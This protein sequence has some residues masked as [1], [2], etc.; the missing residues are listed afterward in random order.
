MGL[1]PLYLTQR[2]LNIAISTSNCLKTVARCCARLLHAECPAP[3]AVSHVPPQT[4]VAPRPSLRQGP[5]ALPE[6][7]QALPPGADQGFPGLQSA[8][9]PGCFPMGHACLWPHSCQTPRR[10][11]PGTPLPHGPTGPAA[12]LRSVLPGTRRLAPATRVRFLYFA[13]FNPPPPQKGPKPRCLCCLEVGWARGNHPRTAPQGRGAQDNRLAL[14]GLARKGVAHFLR[15]HRLTPEPACPETG[16]SGS[17]T[18]PTSSGIGEGVLRPSRPAAA[19]TG[20]ETT[21]HVDSSSGSGCRGQSQ[22]SSGWDPS[23]EPAV[24]GG[25]PGVPGVSL[26]GAAGA[27]PPGC[28]PK[29]PAVIAAAGQA[30][31][32]KARGPIAASRHPGSGWQAQ[33]A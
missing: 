10:P 1:S 17:G 7:T 8:P 14:P 29:C 31:G 6:V 26:G 21:A 9:H 30:E 12:G 5:R 19:H 3:K 11:S 25:G 23:T 32:H 4:T 33:A 22:L 20:A 18:W 16:T 28:R 2:Y 24:R 27:C 15:A 13:S